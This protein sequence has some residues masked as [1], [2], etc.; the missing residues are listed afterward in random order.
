MASVLFFPLVPH[1]SLWKED[2]P[3]PLEASASVWRRYSEFE[4]LRNYLLFC[5]PYIVVAPLPEKR[6]SLGWQKPPDDPFDPDFLDRRRAGLEVC[7][8]YTFSWPKREIQL[9][10]EFI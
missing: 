8:V 10:C 3:V 9:R 1:T 4:L 7:S 2:A 5:Y 6:A